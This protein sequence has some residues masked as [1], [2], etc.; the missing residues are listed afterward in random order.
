MMNQPRRAGRAGGIILLAFLSLFALSNFLTLILSMVAA[1]EYWALDNEDLEPQIETSPTPQD[2]PIPFLDQLQSDTVSGAVKLRVTGI[3]INLAG[4][5]AR[6]Y[7]LLAALAGITWV[8]T[9]IAILRLF[10]KNRSFNH[11]VARY[12]FRVIGAATSVFLV[13]FYLAYA[14]TGSFILPSS[15]NN[16]PIGWGGAIMAHLNL[17]L[18][19]FITLLAAALDTPK[20]WD[21]PTGPNSGRTSQE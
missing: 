1:G 6:P 16:W 3:P 19:I 8:I 9:S 2:W 18:G 5:L 7:V 4:N 20:D 10:T 13:I 14:H 21:A 15:V 12:V 11:R 17:L